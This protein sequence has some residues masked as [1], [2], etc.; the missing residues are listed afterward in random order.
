MIE[1]P[2][3][4]RWV[5]AHGIA[6]DPEGWREALGGG[7]AVGHDRAKLIVVAGEVETG[8]MARLATRP[9]VILVEREELALA[10]GRR[11][12]RALLMTLPDPSTLP[13]YEGATPLGDPSGWPQSLRAAL[14]ICLGSR[15]PIALYWGR[16]LTLLYNDAWSPILGAKHP[17]ALGRAGREVWPELWDS[18]GPMFEQVMTAGESTYS[19]DQLLPM[20]RHGYTEECYFNY[21]FTPI[22]GDQRRVDGVFNAVVAEGDFVGRSVYEGR[23]AGAGPTASAVVAD[24]IDIACGRRVPTFGVA[25]SRLQ[26]QPIVP[27]V[28]A[29]V[30]ILMDQIASGEIEPQHKVIAG[31]LIVRTSARLPKKGVIERDGVQFYKPA[32]AR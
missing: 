9:H 6:A 19:E 30:D 29:T 2:D 4:P 7:F 15:F 22:H 12:E 8:D 25:A 14:G 10:T 16:E 24:L 18:I 11:C 1:L 21:T 20:R 31:E 17:W 27:M 3:L 28:E 5:E 23:G 32:G 13:D 26:P